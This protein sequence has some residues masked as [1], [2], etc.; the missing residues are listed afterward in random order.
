MQ[1]RGEKTMQKRSER[2]GLSGVPQ[3]QGPLV[4]RSELGSKKTRVPDDDKTVGNPGISMVRPVGAA[5][6]VSDASCRR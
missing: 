1:S 2:R 3:V 4:P 6:P 5:G